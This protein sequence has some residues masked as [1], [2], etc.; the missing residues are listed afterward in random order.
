M[1]RFNPTVLDMQVPADKTRNR[2]NNQELFGTLY[3]IHNKS[4]GVRKK[5]KCI[6]GVPSAV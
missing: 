5:A 4:E 3:F 1:Y 6:T 2:Q